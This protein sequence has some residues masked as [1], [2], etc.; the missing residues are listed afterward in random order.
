MTRSAAP[1]AFDPA[2]PFRLCADWH[3]S[4]VT[5]KFALDAMPA[6]SLSIRWHSLVSMLAVCIPPQF[7]QEVIG[8]RTG[9]SQTRTGKTLSAVRDFG[10]GVASSEARATWSQLSPPS[11]IPLA[12]VVLKK[13]RREYINSAWYRASG[14]QLHP[15]HGGDT[16]EID[17]S[18]SRWVEDVAIDDLQIR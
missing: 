13:L 11:T 7:R 15:P 6:R 3:L 5:G 10:M 9:S 14:Q 12:A 16:L 2:R 8:R 4:K 17:N 18:S 1:T